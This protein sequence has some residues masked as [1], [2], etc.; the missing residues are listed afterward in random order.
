[1][2][3]WM[4]LSKRLAENLP[5]PQPQ[6]VLATNSTLCESVPNPS[7]VD[8]TTAPAEL[9]FEDVEKLEK[10]ARRLKKLEVAI[11]SDSQKIDGDIKALK[12]A[13]S[14]QGGGL[15]VGRKKLTG[16]EDFLVDYQLGIN[17]LTVRTR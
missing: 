1:M 11:R 17:L 16:K 6:K 10:E 14:Y 4:A 13:D 3:K 15:V 9:S 5:A 7:R 8:R 12:A 2:D